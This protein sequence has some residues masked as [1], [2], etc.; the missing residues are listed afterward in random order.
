MPV[1]AHSLLYMLIVV[2]PG[3]VLISLTNTSPR[4]A[5][6]QEVDAAQAGAVDRAERVDG[7]A[8]AGARPSRRARR[9]GIAS[10]L[11]PSR[12]LAS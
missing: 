11:A 10:R 1:A 12:Y 2:K 4:C 5:V 3:I 8:P 7:Q 6:D 9:P